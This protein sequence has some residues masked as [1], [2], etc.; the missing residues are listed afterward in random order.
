MLLNLATNQEDAS[1]QAEPVSEVET[2]EAQIDQPTEVTE[3]NEPEQTDNPEGEPEQTEE[4]VAEIEEEEV[5]WEDGQKYRVPKPLKDAL[6]RQSDYTRKTK[7]VAAERRQNAERIANWESEGEELAQAR[8][9]MLNINARLAEIDGI[10]DAQWNHLYQNDPAKA[11]SLEREAR[12]LRDQAGQVDRA[13]ADFTSRRTAEQETER[14]NLRQAMFTEVQKHIPEWDN[15][16]GDEVADFAMSRFGVEPEALLQLTD[17][18]ALRILH[19]AFVGDKAVKAQ[20]TTNIIAQRQKTSPAQTV[21]GQG[22]KFQ[23]PDDSSDFA[24]LEKRMDEAL[25]KR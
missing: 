16:L 17:P 9:I 12:K 10:S 14:S 8:A 7:E 2:T 4:T 1:P 6:L 5:E 23:A 20:K 25:A 15:K 22:G 21:R 11:T 24:A 3:T 19:A 18:T 13:V